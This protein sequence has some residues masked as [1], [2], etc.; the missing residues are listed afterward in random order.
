[1]FGDSKALDEKPCDSVNTMW[2]QLHLLCPIC[3]QLS[4]SLAELF[5]S[6]KCTHRRWRRPQ[7]S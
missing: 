4:V 7:R 3:R 1:M 2:S 5:V 6:L